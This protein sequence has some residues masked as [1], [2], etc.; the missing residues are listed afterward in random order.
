MKQ[1]KLSIFKRDICAREYCYRSDLDKIIKIEPYF[2]AEKIGEEILYECEIPMPLLAEKDQFYI[3]ETDE[4]ITIRKVIRTPSDKIVYCIEGYTYKDDT[5]ENMKESYNYAMH[6]RENFIMRLY[7]KKS[8]WYKLKYSFE[9]F[10]NN[11]KVN[12]EK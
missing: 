6:A 9:E 2:S 10:K 11:Y 4:P 5:E 7:N 1:V 12:V 3:D 8:W